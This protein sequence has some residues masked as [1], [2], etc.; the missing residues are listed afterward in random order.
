MD[1][2]AVGAEGDGF[3]GDLPAEGVVL[4]HDEVAD[5][6]AGLADI[7]L[8]GPAAI[9]GE[10]VA[11]Q[12]EATHRFAHLLGHEW[13]SG[14]E[15]QQ[16]AMVILMRLGDLLTAHVGSLRPFPARAG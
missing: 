16:A 12:A 11:G 13:V 15:V 6:S 8:V 4:G 9:V 5:H 7:D 14:E 2:G 10:L 1:V 3:R